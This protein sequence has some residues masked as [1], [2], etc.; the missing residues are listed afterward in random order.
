[1]SAEQVCLGGQ[2]G[3]WMRVA[4]SDAKLRRAV[5]GS[6]PAARSHAT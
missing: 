3:R 6:E 5:T 2:E 4:L 1:M